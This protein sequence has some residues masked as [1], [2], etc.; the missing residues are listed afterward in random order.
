MIRSSEKEKVLIS[1]S[2]DGWNGLMS[3]LYNCMAF[4]DI[5]GYFSSR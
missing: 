4:I 1:N 3:A 5:A 2:A